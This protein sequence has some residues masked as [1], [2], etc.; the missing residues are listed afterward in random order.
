MRTK[1]NTR[2]WTEEEINYV[3]GHHQIISTTELSR[4]LEC[5]YQQVWW[6]MKKL[7]LKPKKILKSSGKEK[8]K[9]IIRQWTEDEI[10]YVRGH[11]QIIPIAELSR[12][13]GCK[14]QQMRWLMEKLGLKPKKTFHYYSQ[15]EVE[16]AMAGIRKKG[17]A[18][19]AAQETGR[20]VESI[21]C[22]RYQEKKKRNG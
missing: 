5:S 8:T 15:R 18:F 11:H 14:Y 13:V 9:K 17:E 1:E 22:K 21:R 6:L 10:N 12:I 2:H 20:S 4:K 3:K 16:L 19:F 7:G